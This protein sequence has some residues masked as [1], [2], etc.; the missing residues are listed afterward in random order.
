MR[1]EPAIHELGEQTGCIHEC[2]E[3]V[4][5]HGRIV[6]VARVELRMHVIPVAIEKR[7][8]EREAIREPGNTLASKPRSRKP[9]DHAQVSRARH[10]L[11]AQGVRRRPVGRHGGD[12]RGAVFRFRTSADGFLEFAESRVVFE[13]GAAR[14][15]IRQRVQPFRPILMSDE[16]SFHGLRCALNS[17]SPFICLLLQTTRER[18]LYSID[19]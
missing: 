4:D 19:F 3:C 5:P 8:G 12:E 14:R 7:R 10:Q 11:D 6:A 9:R 13:I 15:F 2:G 18:P 1:H 16:F 17:G